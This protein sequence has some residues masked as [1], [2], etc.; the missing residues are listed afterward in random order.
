MIV[1]GEYWGNY[2]NRYFQICVKL[3]SKDGVALNNH[4]TNNVCIYGRISLV[5][6]C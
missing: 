5:V 6:R 2:S 4:V 3:S 1:T